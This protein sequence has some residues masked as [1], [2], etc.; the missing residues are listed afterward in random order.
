VNYQKSHPHPEETMMANPD[1]HA[2]TGTE[3]AENC[4]LCLNNNCDIKLIPCLHLLHWDCQ[5][6]NSALNLGTCPVCRD[7]IGDFYNLENGTW[8]YNG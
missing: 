6:P 8:V 5:G 7:Q 3:A 1:N 4:P 2:Q